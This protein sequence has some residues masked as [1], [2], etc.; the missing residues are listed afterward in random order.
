MDTYQGVIE[1]PESERDGVTEVVKKIASDSKFRTDFIK[2]P[3]SAVASS[4]VNL[5]KS[6]VD[7]LSD[8]ASGAK[9]LTQGGTSAATAVVVIVII[10]Q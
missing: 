6:T 2:D 4:G 8:L 7:K 9:T 5:S 3:R 10:K 1:V